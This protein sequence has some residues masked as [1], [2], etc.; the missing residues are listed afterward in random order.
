VDAPD[1]I[2]ILIWERGVGPTLSSGTGSSA[3]AVAVAA[4]GGASKSIDVMAPGGLQHVDWTDD[5]IYLTGWAELVL[6][7]EWLGEGGGR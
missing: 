3:A 1:R 6:D 2:R 7:G 5:G 4:H